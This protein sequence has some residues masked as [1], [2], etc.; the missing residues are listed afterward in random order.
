MRDLLIKTAKHVSPADPDESSIAGIVDAYAMLE[1]AEAPRESDAPEEGRSTELEARIAAPRMR[2]RR[3]LIKTPPGRS[4][5][6]HSQTVRAS[7]PPRKPNSP[8]KRKFF[9]S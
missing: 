6:T 3:R 5:L 1:A 4:S 8:E 2:N 9:G 7:Q